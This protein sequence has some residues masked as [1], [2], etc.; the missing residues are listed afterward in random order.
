[1]L[2][3][4]RYAWIDRPWLLNEKDGKTDDTKQKVGLE[5]KR[6]RISKGSSSGNATD[7]YDVRDDIYVA[8]DDLALQQQ[9]QQEEE[10]E[11]KKEEEEELIAAANRLE[12][13]L[14]PAPPP[15]IT[16][17]PLPPP[18]IAYL[19]PPPPPPLPSPPAT[20]KGI[21]AALQVSGVR[22]QKINFILFLLM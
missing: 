10:E 7:A 21:N 11:R 16:P 1:M 18:P 17:P 6:E 15:P 13:L 22:R 8:E 5:K 12:Q 14:N 19:P 3:C 20:S 4:Y 2:V 9:Q